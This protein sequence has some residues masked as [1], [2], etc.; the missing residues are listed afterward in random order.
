MTSALLFSAS[1]VCA[2]ESYKDY[3]NRQSEATDQFQHE[4]SEY[5][6]QK[7]ELMMKREEEQLAAK[8]TQ[9]RICFHGGDTNLALQ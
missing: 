3:L 5:R 4:L 6:S 7:S 1:N 9:Q 8:R 2:V